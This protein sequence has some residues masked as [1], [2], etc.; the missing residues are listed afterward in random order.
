MPPGGLERAARH[1]VG[2]EEVGVV[3]EVGVDMGDILF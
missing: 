2:V 3:R 1:M